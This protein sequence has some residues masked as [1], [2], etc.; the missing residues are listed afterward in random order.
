MLASTEVDLAF[1]I[2]RTSLLLERWSVLACS[3]S[4]HT[5]LVSECHHKRG[6]Q[7]LN[8]VT[9]SAFSAA[10]QT[11]MDLEQLQKE[12]LTVVEETM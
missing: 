8:S 2:R 1:S 10:L 3:T 4:Q 9:N 6:V 11:D 12:L 5:L 7:V